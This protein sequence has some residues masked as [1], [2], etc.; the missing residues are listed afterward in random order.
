MIDT[1]WRC[2]ECGESFDWDD[3]PPCRGCG[4]CG[5]C[6]PPCRGCGLCVACCDCCEPEDEGEDI[7]SVREHTDGEAQP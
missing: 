3:N 4:L 5:A 2:S 6:C 1:D 7:E